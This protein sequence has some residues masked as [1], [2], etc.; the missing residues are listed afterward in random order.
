LKENVTFKP[1]KSPIKRLNYFMKDKEGN[2]LSRKEFFSRWKK[3]IEGITPLQQTKTQMHSSFI[4]IIGILA[5]I[6]ICIIGIKTLWW[7]LIILV[8]AL[9]N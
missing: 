7:L 3:G 1:I 9:L 5:G 4:M 6:V 2:E 8:G